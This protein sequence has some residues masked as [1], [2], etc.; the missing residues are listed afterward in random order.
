MIKKNYLLSVAACPLLFSFPALAQSDGSSRD[1]E[2]AARPAVGGGEIVVTARRRAEGIESVPAAITAFGAAQIQERG[3]RTEEDLQSATPGLVLRQTQGQNQLNYSIR[4]QTVDA[5]T[6]SSPSVVPYVNDVQ[7]N[8][9]GA[10]SF[11]DIESIQV[12]KG[13]Q[14]TLFGRNATGGAVL[15]GTA[16]P[17]DE[18]EGYLQFTAGNYEFF[19]GQGAINAPI[20]A[21][22]VLL[23]LAFDLATRKGFQTNIFNGKKLGSLRTATGR[24]SLTLRPSSDFEN[25]TVF[26][27]GKQGGTNT[28]LKAFSIY[29]NGATGP[30]GTPLSSAVSDF[31]SPAGFEAT[32]GPGSWSQYIAANPGIVRSQPNALQT[33]LPGFLPYLKTLPFYSTVSLEENRHRATVYFGTNTTSYEVGSNI[34]L[35]N[36]LGY[37]Y[38]HTLDDQPQLGIP[39]GAQ[40]TGNLNLGQFGNDVKSKSFSEELQ[41]QGKALN[42]RLDFIVGGYYQKSSQS[43]FY[44]QTYYNVYP[45]PGVNGPYGFGNTSDY[46]NTNTS[47]AIFAQATYDFSDAGLNGLSLTGGLRYTWEKVTLKHL[48]RSTNRNGEFQSLDFKKPSWEVGLTY[49]ATPELLTYIKTRGSWRSGGLNGNAAPIDAPASGGGNQFSPETVKDVEAGAKF[50]GRVLGRP[51]SLNVAVYKMWIKN[52]QRFLTP[53][54]CDPDLGVCYSLA[55]TATVPSAKVQGIEIDGTINPASWLTIGGSFAYTDAKFSNNVALLYGV[56][57]VFNPYPDTPKV[58]GSAFM[59]V[60]LPVSSDLGDMSLRGDVYAQ[61]AQYFSA[62]AGS[63]MPQTRLPAYT[64]VNAR[65]EWRNIA[66]SS[67]SFSAFVRNLLDEK[68]YSGGLAEGAS[69]GANGAAVGR[70]R[71]FGAEVRLDF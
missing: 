6:G 39:Y 56:D 70:P 17:T 13:P 29:N 28:G 31:Y 27:Y 55:V 24:A 19:Q 32:F 44:P 49:Q 45:L 52:V 38:S 54:V 2:G 66:G 34:T 40:Y 10:S 5:Y 43:I 37:S 57:Y 9:G 47:K 23:R 12:L 60:A 63:S 8:A 18:F 20:V 21:E 22:K 61:S 59:R 41:L 4:G 35:K 67:F 36:I 3:L 26:Q 71:M 11:F 65:Y 48:T 16:K 58:S 1:S 25:T 30:D 14:G 50:S 42:D 51:A 33:G 64:L 68:Y 7:L 69:F 46:K 53:T 62:N 15:Y